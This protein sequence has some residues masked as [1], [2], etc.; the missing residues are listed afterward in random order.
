MNNDNDIRKNPEQ[1]ADI[2]SRFANAM[3][4]EQVGFAQAITRQHRTLQQSIFGL[5][6]R[7]IEEWSKQEHFDPRN[8]YTVETSKKIMDLLGGHSGTPFI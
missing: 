3:C 1:M 4:V 6:L 2:L 5:F 8:E 7:T